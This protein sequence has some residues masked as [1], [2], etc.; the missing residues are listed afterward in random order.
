[1]RLAF[2][3]GETNINY[4][5]TPGYLKNAMQHPAVQRLRIDFEKQ[6]E[7]ALLALWDGTTMRSGVRT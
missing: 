7:A 1:V 2:E 6:L 3:R 5:T 4:D